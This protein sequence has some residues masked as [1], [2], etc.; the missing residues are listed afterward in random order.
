[1]R[2]IDVVLHRE[3]FDA[4]QHSPT[5]SSGNL[6]S[7]LS[8]L[9]A[10]WNIQL[11]HYDNHSSQ[12]TKLRLYYFSSLSQLTG[13]DFLRHTSQTPVRNA[14]YSIAIFDFP[15]NGLCPDAALWFQDILIYTKD[16]SSLVKQ[17]HK[18]ELNLRKTS[19]HSSNQYIVDAFSNM[20]FVG[21]SPQYR[22]LI[23]DTTRMAECRAPV[24]IE[25]ETGTGK[26][27]LARA[28]HYLSDRKSQGF[29]PVNCAAIPDELL[30][31]ELFG[32]EKGA[33]THAQQKNPGLIELAEGGSLFLDEVDSLSTKAQTALLRF[34]QTGES[35]PV[36]GS[37][38]KQTDV[39]IIAATNT[40]LAD[41]VNRGYFREDLLYRLNVLNIQVP[42]LRERISDLDVIAKHLL[43]CFEQ[44]YNRGQK[45]LHPELLNWL[46]QQSWPGNVRELENYLLRLYL[47]NDKTVLNL[48][49]KHRS[50]A[51]NKKTSNADYFQLS[52]QEAKEQT[53]N[54]FTEHYIASL[55]NQTNGN[56][57]RAAE[58]AGKERRAFG[59]LMK[60]HNI[61]SRY[62]CQA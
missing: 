7:I 15:T 30:E 47:L 13:I 21:E 62:F 51:P 33:F 14:L 59:K 40:P 12:N 37:R 19:A 1:M 41:C 20:N 46:K 27:L 25:G 23:A 6:E 24:L 39:R 49:E 44:K 3:L 53:L 43:C 60:K 35:R 10:Y 31:S 58:L 29:I 2:T 50:P 17:L 45:L 9:K 22:S 48:E 42:P 54:Q 38:F 11:Q 34:L 55:L 61:D 8:Y 56:I 26:E 32:H 57:S 18:A 16:L 28:L 4:A 5:S 36:G 52:Y